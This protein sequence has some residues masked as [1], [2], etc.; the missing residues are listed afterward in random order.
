MTSV[1]SSPWRHVQIWD[2]CSERLVWEGVYKSQ[3]ALTDDSVAFLCVLSVL[4]I[5]EHPD[6]PRGLG[7]VDSREFV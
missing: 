3:V 2:L 6:C 5:L 7:S 4:P 1:A